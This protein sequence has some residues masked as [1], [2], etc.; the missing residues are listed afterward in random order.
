MDHFTLTDYRIQD[1][2]SDQIVVMVTGNR[3]YKTV[4]CTA[5]PRPFR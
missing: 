2:G 1:A 5:F 3:I 4:L